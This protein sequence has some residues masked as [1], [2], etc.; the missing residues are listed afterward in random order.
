MPIPNGTELG[1]S[2]DIGAF[3]HQPNADAI[4]WDGFEA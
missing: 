1:S 2:A 4:F 3:E